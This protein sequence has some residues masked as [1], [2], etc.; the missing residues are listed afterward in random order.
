MKLVE[1]KY[2]IHDLDEHTTIVLQFAPAE[3]YSG[4]LYT[5]CIT[6]SHLKDEQD[7]SRSSLSRTEC[8]WLTILNLNKG[9]LKPELPSVHGTGVMSPKGPQTEMA[10]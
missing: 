4:Y 2:N 6:V 10:T 7:E 5:E 3:V 9:R 1:Q 8:N